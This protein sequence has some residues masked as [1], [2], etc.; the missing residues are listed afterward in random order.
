MSCGDAAD[1]VDGVDGKKAEALMPSKPPL[2]ILASSGLTAQRNGLCGGSRRA[3]VN[4]VGSPRPSLSSVPLHTA[5]EL[6]PA[7][8]INL[9]L[10]LP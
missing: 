7:W 3:L 8:D 9:D 4:D 1:G 2:L 10:Y 5:R 6:G